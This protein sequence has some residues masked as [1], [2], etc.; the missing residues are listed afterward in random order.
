[1]PTPLSPDPAGGERRLTGAATPSSR[2]GAAGHDHGEELRHRSRR[3]LLAA[4]AL[5]A[6]FMVVEV[7]GGLISGSL[8]VLADAGHM[9]ADSAAIGLALV[10]MHFSHRA[11]SVRRTFGYQRLEILAALV[12][13][14]A[15]L[16]IAGWV[17]IEAF[18]RIQAAPEVRGG[19]TLLVGVAGLLVNLFAAWILRDPAKDNLNV[20]GA[21]RHVLADLFGSV[22]VVVSGALIW[23]FDWR[24]ADPIVGIVI[25]LLIVVSTFRLLTRVVHVLLEGTPDHIDLYEVCSKLEDEEGVMLIHDVHVWTITQ[26]YE[27]LT[28]HVLIDP[29]WPL[30]Q[31]DALLRRL[32]RICSERF[33]IRH[34]TLQLEGSAEGCVENDHVFHL[35]YRRRSE[36][37][38]PPPEPWPTGT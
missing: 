12:N 5:I 29:A 9:F 27:S 19:L 23:A 36:A 35:E 7:V 18:G 8:A 16:A 6:T 31:R 17:L 26:G 10:A 2:S 13:S 33:G 14:L 3:R 15:L 11:A 30:D 28:A 21:F 37:P 22:G 20:D 38:R 32:R 34:V 4:L 25:A 24:L 1:M